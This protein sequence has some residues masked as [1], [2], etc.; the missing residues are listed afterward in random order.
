MPAM[1]AY[2]PSA[3]LIGSK[4]RVSAII[5]KPII[6]Y[7]VNLQIDSVVILLLV[8]VSLLI[9]VLKTVFR[10]VLCGVRDRTKE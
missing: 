3:C 8:L 9:K 2:A 4:S 6:T 7:F 5:T 1:K 10:L